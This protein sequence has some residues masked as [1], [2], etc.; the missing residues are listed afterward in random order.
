MMEHSLSLFRY[1]EALV[2]RAEIG[3]FVG[4]GT[5]PAVADDNPML[6]RM[7]RAR[8]VG[9]V[10]LVLAARSKG[11]PLRPTP[12]TEDDIYFISR[13]FPMWAADNPTR[14]FSISRLLW[15][16]R[17]T[18]YYKDLQAFWI[19]YAPRGALAEVMWEEGARGRSLEDMMDDALARHNDYATR[20]RIDPAKQKDRMPGTGPREKLTTGLDT[21]SVAVLS[22]DDA[23]LALHIWMAHQLKSGV[24][25]GSPP[26]VIR[27]LFINTG[28][29][30]MDLLAKR[31]KAYEA[32]RDAEVARRKR[33]A[34]EIEAELKGQPSRE[35]VD[36]LRAEFRELL[37][38]L[39]DPADLIEQGPSPFSSSPV[40]RCVAARDNLLSTYANEGVLGEGSLALP[41]LLGGDSQ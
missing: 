3:N 33:R 38:P 19:V 40:S 26:K 32:A 18:P 1:T 28:A 5:V 4:L 9:L 7:T 10:R 37:T 6:E 34:T 21:L 12:I 35:R 14:N 23:G 39:E 15:S 17:N 24:G 8:P 11:D 36:E 22:H 41:T 13:M 30:S 25:S 20:K 16:F 27:D 31:K 29:P 2:Y